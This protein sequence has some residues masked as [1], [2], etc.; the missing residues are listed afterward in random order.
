MLD[1]S[2][3]LLDVSM[4]FPLLVPRLRDSSLEFPLWILVP[5]IRDSSLKFSS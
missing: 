5:Q 1:V 2:C 3:Q 4:Q